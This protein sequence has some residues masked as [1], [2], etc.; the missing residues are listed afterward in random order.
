[1]RNLQIMKPLIL[2]FASAFVMASC[3]SESFDLTASPDEIVVLRANALATPAEVFAKV[4]PSVVF[5]E[6]SDTT[7]SGVLLPSGFVLTNAHLVGHHPTVRLVTSTGEVAEVPVYA[8][9]WSTDLA[10]IGPVPFDELDGELS[11]VD[12]GSSAEA[13]VGDSVYLI[14]YPGEVESHPV[15]AM[16]SGI[17]SRRRIDPCLGMTFLQTDAVI[18]GGQSGG[19]LVD[20]NGQVIGISGLGAFG[21][22]FALVLSAE[23]V[24]AALDGLEEGAGNLANVEVPGSLKQS[25]EVA[26]YDSAG[27]LV[28][29][30]ED[31]PSLTVTARSEDGEDVWLDIRKWDGADPPWRWSQGELDFMYASGEEETG[32]YHAD[33][34][35][36]GR[37][38]S[39]KVSLQPGMYVVATGTYSGTDTTIAVEASTPLKPIQDAEPSRGKLE[40]GESATGLFS[41]FEDLDSYRIDL[42]KGDRVRIQALSLADPVMSLYLDDE[43]VAS[44]DDAGI[45]LYGDGAEIVFEAESTGQYVLEVMAFRTEFKAYVLTL[46]HADDRTPSC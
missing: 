30:T 38:E 45:G 4:S 25:S 36:D 37:T 15:P 22:S 10:V 12:L 26:I 40:I 16:T 29:I 31:Q 5:V 9:D 7:G 20:S 41:H 14:G 6:V 32:P 43:L 42:R 44:N 18:T 24:I 34:F 46:S 3:G 33:S 21:E 2:F 11:A 8:K 27:Y 35:D 19:V 39:L 1:M 13:N 23:D 28:T 17:L